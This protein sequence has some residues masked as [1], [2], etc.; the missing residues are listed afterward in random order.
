MSSIQLQTP[1]LEGGIRSI[2]FF[3]GRLLSAEDLTQ[4]A[5]AQQDARKRLGQAMGD[6]VASGLEVLPIA[7][8]ATKQNPVV[9]IT[10]GLAVN[11]CGRTLA[12]PVDVDI[13]LVRPQDSQ[14]TIQT[15]TFDDCQPLQ[16]GTYVA[17]AGVYL[18]TIG[19]A[20]GNEGRA[21][22][23]GLGN[24][25]ASCN[26]RYVVEGVQFRLLQIDLSLN[27]LND[28]DHLRN[29]L[30]HAC[31]GTTDTGMQ[32]FFRDPFNTLV[33]GYG[34]LDM[35][36]PNHLTDCEVP[37]ALLYWTIDDGIAF[38][39]MW[40]VR[41][42]LTSPATMNRRWS[43]LLNDRRLAEAEAMFLQFEDQIEDIRAR[44]ADAMANI[45]A[46][47]R[48]DSL[49]PL[50]MLP[51]VAGG[52]PRGFDALTFFGEHA[53]RDIAMIDANLLRHLLHEALYHEAID[54]SAP[55]K[56]QLYT[57]FENVQ[58]LRAQQTYQLALV[59]A[60]HALPYSGVAR[61]GFA[62]WDLSRFA[63]TVL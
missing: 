45:E 43:P 63:T 53:S 18:L 35:L 32:A 21:P 50:G 7:G 29:R 49:P 60:S 62:R 31:F 51:V 11:R 56:I 20:S 38:V 5:A 52:S 25:A 17:G 4:E 46:A 27:T 14:T 28:R 37:L 47:Q 8:A 15:A 13:S 48:F 9:T 34:L 16:S 57:I 19:P 42:R 1:I 61:F 2:N 23:S 36:R 55:D 54:L 41:R 24:V 40:S 30:A 12:L 26:S 22:V 3:N 33:D 58:A 10:R 39:D 6:G 59:F 44:E